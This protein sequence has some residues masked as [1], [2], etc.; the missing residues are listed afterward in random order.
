MVLEKAVGN[1]A[2]RIAIICAG[3]D[4]YYT[5]EDLL[6][7]GCLV[8][9]LSQGLHQMGQSRPECNGQ[10]EIVRGRWQDF[11]AGLSPEC[12]KEPEDNP[13]QIGNQ[14][15]CKQLFNRLRLSRGGKNLVSL[16]LTCDIAFAAGM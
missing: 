1:P 7:A 15:F 2:L 6:L 10:A 4:G 3:T 11:V 14:A 8:E 16:N 9:R 5:D 12:M 13:E